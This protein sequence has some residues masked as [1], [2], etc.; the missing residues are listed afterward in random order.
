M[1]A[2]AFGSVDVLPGTPVDITSTVTVV[3]S[4][5]SSQGQRICISLDAGSASDGTSRQ[6]TGPGAAKTRFDLYKNAARTQVW[7]S[8]VTGYQNSGVQVDVARDST[9][10][11]TVYG[12]FL[13]AQQ[14]A[15][16]GTYT[17]TFSANPHIQYGNKSQA[18]CP[19]GNKTATTSTSATATVISNCSVSATSVNFGI[20]SVLTSNIDAVGT[21][22]IQCSPAL[23]YTVSLSG[24]NSGASDPTQRKMAFGAQ[25]V[26]YGLYR[27]SARTLP[28]GAIAGVNTASGSGSGVAQN[29]TVFG[30]IAP[31]L[32]PI[33]GSYSDTIIA[34]VAY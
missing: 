12:R 34:T 17:S 4:G 21:L 30:R 20:T 5:G 3:C 9:T 1:P 11:V 27:D 8:W 7:G 6:L 28:W 15:A 16:P 26:T 33:P 14:T 13:G 2:V 10:S 23:P 25:Q 19:A 31:Q 32:T 18:Q 22:A 29:L 24:G